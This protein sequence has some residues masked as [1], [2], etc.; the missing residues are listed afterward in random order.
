VEKY[1]QQHISRREEEWGLGVAGASACRPRART[2]IPLSNS[3]HRRLPQTTD[4]KG[5]EEDCG[6][7][8]PACENHLRA[9]A[10]HTPVRVCSEET[11]LV[12]VEV[13]D[14]IDNNREVRVVLNLEE[15]CRSRFENFDFRSEPNSAKNTVQE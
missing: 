15:E 3:N 11:R 2:G 10:N 8:M 14:D 12:L 6:L 4:S 13:E 1:K 7:H 9:R 5:G